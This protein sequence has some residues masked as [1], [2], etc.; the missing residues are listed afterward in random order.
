MKRLL[1]LILITCTLALAAG[2]IEV[3]ADKLQDQIRGGLL[4]HIIGDLNGLKHENKYFAEPGN[5][6][7]YVP[8]LPEGAWTDDDTDVEWIYILEMQRANTLLIAPPRIAELWKR[9]INRRI[10]CSHL[11]LRQMLDIGIEPPLTGS[12][13]LN[14]WAEFNLSGQFVSESWGH[15]APGMP[16]TAA[17][18]GTHYLHVSID[19]EPIQSTQL[20]AAM[21]ATAF[22]TSDIDKIVDAGVA[23]TDPKSD[24]HKI[25]LNVRKWHRQN[26]QDWRATRKLIQ[27]TWS[28]G[29]RTADINGVKLNGASAVA[30]VLYGKGDFVETVRHAFNFGFDADNNAAT[31]GAIVGV[32]KGRKWMMDQGWNIKD[33]FRNTSR[34]DMPMDETITSFGDR[35]IALAER[36]VAEHG[37]AKITKSG[38]TVYRIQTEDAANIERLPDPGKQFTAL[39]A[40]LK[41]EIEKAVASGAATPQQQARAAYLAICL[42]LAA[43]LKQTYPQQWARAIEALSGYSKLMQVL[44]FQESTP[45]GDKLIEKAVAAGLRKPEKRE[46]FS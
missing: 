21:I 30:A 5:V 3:T 24:M 18:I 38:K 28:V 42:D 15:I 33:V 10:W 32:I 6:Q 41:P 27:Q 7:S 39:E 20:F 25:V 29:N 14:P 22:V 34:D 37:G 1:Y 26:P 45:A 13:H 19:G 9:H 44:F 23:A 4:G 36:V 17:R 43:K 8:E 40:K 2:K 31:A 35:L 16:Q 46:K 12:V 11:Y